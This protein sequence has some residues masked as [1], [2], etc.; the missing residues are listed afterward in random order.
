MVLNQL[1]PDGTVSLRAQRE[2]RGFLRTTLN[3]SAAPYATEP[4]TPVT[5]KP[6]QANCGL[7]KTNWMIACCGALPTS[8]RTKT[9]Q[10]RAVVTQ[11]DQKK[12]G[13]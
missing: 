5:E 8:A 1:F 3:G 12:T 7:E 11:M 4:D 2:V 13:F 6:I 9:D 10:L